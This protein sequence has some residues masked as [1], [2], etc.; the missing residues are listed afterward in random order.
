MPWYKA[1]R[2]NFSNVVPNGTCNFFCV[3]L[4]QNDKIQKLSISI[5]VEDLDFL[6]NNHKDNVF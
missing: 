2:V 4:I 1:K 3:V 5:Q 6:I